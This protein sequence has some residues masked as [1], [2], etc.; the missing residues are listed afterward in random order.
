MEY[1]S[2][3]DIKKRTKHL[4][5]RKAIFTQRAK[6]VRNELIMTRRKQ[7]NSLLKIGRHHGGKLFNLQTDMNQKRITHI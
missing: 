5:Q 1:L 2:T 6:N 7:L 4:D 3:Y